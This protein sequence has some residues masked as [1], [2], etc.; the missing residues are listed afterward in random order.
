MCVVNGFCRNDL[1]VHLVI[2]FFALD[3]KLAT[4]NN[5][6]ATDQLDEASVAQGQGAGVYYGTRAILIQDALTIL[7][8]VLKNGQYTCNFVVEI[9]V[10]SDWSDIL[11]YMTVC[12]TS[13]RG[14]NI[15]TY[16]MRI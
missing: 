1:P 9:G 5:S 13:W 2:N 10:Y 14:L 16:C 15:Y 3:W 8:V 6:A 7:D 12:K 4:F 11:R